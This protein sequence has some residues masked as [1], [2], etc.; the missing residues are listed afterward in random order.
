MYGIAKLILTEGVLRGP[1]CTVGARMIF[2]VKRAEQFHDLT[3]RCLQAQFIQSAQTA[4]CNA[5]HTVEQ[6]MARWLLLCADRVGDS[7]L[8]LS[9]EFM[10]DMMGVTRSSVTIVAGR[11]QEQGLIQYTRGKIKLTDVA[12][13]EALACECY[14][15]VRSHLHSF[16]D[17]VETY[18]T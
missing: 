9:H 16:A 2:S 5:R 15:V 8:P 7:V 4:A 11:L 6:R 12:G 18:G 17:N 13:L 10:A 14:R 1:Q 3:L